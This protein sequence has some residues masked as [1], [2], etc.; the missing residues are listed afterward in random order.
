LPRLFA[1]YIAKSA[2]ASS[3]STPCVADVPSATPT[4]PRATTGRP[5]SSTGVSSDSS[6]RSAMA[7]ASR[8][9]GRALQQH[10]ELVAAQTRDGVARPQAAPEPPGDVGQQP[11]HRPGGPGR[12]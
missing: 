11:V 1:W 3:S 4:L 7:M 2:F 12:R 6:S 8:R 10:A 5:S 9:A